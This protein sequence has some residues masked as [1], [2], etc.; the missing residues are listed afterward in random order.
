MELDGIGYGLEVLALYVDKATRRNHLLVGRDLFRS[1]HRRP[2]HTTLVEPRLPGTHR[3]GAETS[4]EFGD[5][6]LAI[7][8]AL[9]CIREPR[10]VGQ[11]LPLD[12][13]QQSR[14]VP[15]G[16]DTEQPK[17]MAVVA[18]VAVDQRCLALGPVDTARNSTEQLLHTQFPTQ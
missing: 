4:I 3:P 7:A 15:V 1:Q 9:A 17:P 16:F 10:I 11:I 6:R 2:P 14:K 12:G 18:A 5:E 8:P 13:S